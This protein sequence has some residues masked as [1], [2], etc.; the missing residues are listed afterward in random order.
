MLSPFPRCR[1]R[2]VPLSCLGALDGGGGVGNGFRAVGRTGTGMGFPTCSQEG[3]Q[4]SGWDRAEVQDGFNDVSGILRV[5]CF[6]AERGTD[7]VLQVV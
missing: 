5:L 7:C 4:G 2:V 1:R 6:V 3:A